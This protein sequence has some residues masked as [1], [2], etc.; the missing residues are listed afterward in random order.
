MSYH[1]LVRKALEYDLE[2]I[3]FLAMAASS[4][5]V[6]VCQ[7]LLRTIMDELRE[8]CFW[9]TLLACHCDGMMPPCP[10]ADGGYQQPSGDY[11]PYQKNSGEVKKEG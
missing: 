3:R 4:A 9:N 5:P 1:H 8:A 10:G 11:Y 7:Q 2:E 6:A